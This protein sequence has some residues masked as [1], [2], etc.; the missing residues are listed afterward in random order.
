MKVAK[1]FT[2]GFFVEHLEF[3]E[4]FKPKDHSVQF[5]HKLLLGTA[6]YVKSLALVFDS[7]AACLIIVTGLDRK[8]DGCSRCEF[9]MGM[10]AKNFLVLILVGNQYQK[11][12][13]K[14]KD[15]Y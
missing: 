12:K 15:K 13:S 6:A 9:T 8:E 5:I 3:P 11:C 10:E 4:A 14:K 1:E 2:N 7:P